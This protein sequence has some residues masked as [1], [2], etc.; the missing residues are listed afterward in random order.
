M[1][2]SEEQDDFEVLSGKIMVPLI[3]RGNRSR[4]E[5]RDTEFHFV[6]TDL[7]LL[8]GHVGSDTLENWNFSLSIRDMSVWSSTRRKLLK[9]TLIQTV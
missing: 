6:H 3:E 9:L 2:R 1:T 4:L 5:E 7:E 8:A